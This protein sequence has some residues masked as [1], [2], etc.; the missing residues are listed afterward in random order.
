MRNAARARKLGRLAAVAGMMFV[1]ALGSGAC[2]GANGGGSGDESVGLAS[3]RLGVRLEPVLSTT[4]TRAARFALA[5]D[6]LAPTLQTELGMLQVA[7]DQTGIDRVIAAHVGPVNAIAR[8]KGIVVTSGQDG[9]LRIWDA[10]TGTRL[11]ERRLKAPI[12][13]MASSASVGGVVLAADQDGGVALWDV[14]TAAA[15]TVRRLVSRH[16]ARGTPLAVGFTIG[17]V[18]AFAAWSDGRVE[19]WDVASGT[20]LSTLDLS[21]ARG[22]LPWSRGAA[23]RLTAATV[24]GD[25]YLS[26]SALDVATTAGAVARIDLHALRG[27]TLVPAG[28][29]ADAITSLAT[30]TYNDPTVVIGTDAGFLL[31]RQK[32]RQ[33]TTGGGGRASVAFFDDKYVVASAD[34]VRTLATGDADQGG[35]ADPVGPPATLAAAGT[36]GAAIGRADGTVTLLGVPGTGLALPSGGSAP[37]ARFGPQGLLLTVEGWD[38]NHVSDLAAVRPVAGDPAD[39]DALPKVRVYKPDRRW[40]PQGDGADDD[41][42]V[43]DATIGDD[44]VAAAGQDP[45]GTAAVLVWNARTGRPLRRLPL[46]TGGVQPST[47]SIATGVHLLPGRHLLAAYSAVQE[48]IVLWSTDTWQRLATI[49]VGPAGG[50]AV[51]PDE[52]RLIVAGLSDEQSNLHGGIRTSRLEFIDVGRKAIDHVVATK[53]TARVAVAPDGHAIATVDNGR[54]RILSSDGRH[55][56]IRPVVLD[57]QLGT[58]V[59]W[60]PDGKVLAVGQRRVGSRSSTPSEAASSLRCRPRATMSRCR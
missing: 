24:P 7:A 32:D 17:G 40:W 42:Y 26:K 46:T 35:T 47:P 51:T 19:R 30:T 44:L 41:W 31:W 54:L 59:A 48:S 49:A 3:K 33:L 16:E 23:L 8:L 45:T 38:S 29:V 2:G 6:R 39:T 27:R 36:G 58:E 22:G 20:R 60:R 5:A 52:S 4:P 1:P 10:A 50:F 14:D 28:R 11:A 57:A 53:D 21:R 18:T 25:E 37:V 12:V 43:G 9:A 56:L 34:G 15:P 13:R 55:D